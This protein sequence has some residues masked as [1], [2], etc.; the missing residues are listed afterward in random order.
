MTAKANRVRAALAT[1]LRESAGAT[2][3]AAVA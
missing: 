2:G 1:L 3:A